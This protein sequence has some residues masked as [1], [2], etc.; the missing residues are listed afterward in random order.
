MPNFTAVAPVNDVPVS[1]TLLP[2]NPMVGAKLVIFANTLKVAVL[3]ALPAALV[4]LILPV[5]APLGTLTLI[6]DAETTVIAPALTV[7]TEA[8]N[9]TSV[10]LFKFVPLIV[11]VAPTAAAVGENAVMVGGL[12]I[13]NIVEL[14]AMPPGVVT[15]TVLLL[16]V[17]GTTAVI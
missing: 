5:I 15:E 13:I 7:P 8:V 2:G 3:V 10:T 11:T 1:T 12:I 9:S 4:T 14:V 16:A 6:D 17:A